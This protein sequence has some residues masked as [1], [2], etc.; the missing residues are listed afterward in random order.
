[1]EL[2]VHEE[3]GEDEVEPDPEESQKLKGQN[4][5][6]RTLCQKCSAEGDSSWQE[7]CRKDQLQELWAQ[8]GFDP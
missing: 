4:T 6:K 7:G 1:M 5:Q 2:R 3:S 8:E